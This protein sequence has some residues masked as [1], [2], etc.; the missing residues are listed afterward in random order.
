M[1]LFYGLASTVK[2]SSFTG[3]KN[4]GAAGASTKIG[5]ISM[6]GSEGSIIDV[7]VSVASDNYY[8]TKSS[9]W[10]INT[11]IYGSGTTRYSS[12]ELAELGPQSNSQ[13]YNG[14]GDL[15][16]QLGLTGDNL[17]IYITIPK[18]GSHG[19]SYDWFCLYSITHQGNKLK[20]PGS[21]WN[22][23]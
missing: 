12:T 7:N 11:Q 19:G 23:T 21:S 18:S 17:D 3:Y 8:T 2:V 14:I 1:A 5:T 20:I 13:G 15:S 6:G 4:C 22:A 10:R 9:S 16:M